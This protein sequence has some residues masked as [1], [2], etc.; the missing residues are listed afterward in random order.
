VKVPPIRADE[1]SRLANWRGAILR[2]NQQLF[3]LMIEQ[4]T[5]QVSSQLQ[6]TWRKLSQHL[7]YQGKLGT[8]LG[9][10]KS[11]APIFM[12][13]EAGARQQAK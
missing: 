5:N 4:T 12:V 1:L 8:L 3:L 7:K 13:L 9:S 2:A 6:I 10:I 11:I